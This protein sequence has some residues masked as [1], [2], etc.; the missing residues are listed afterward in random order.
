MLIR[1]K[2][3]PIFIYG[4]NC[5]RTCLQLKKSSRY[6]KLFLTKSI[7]NKEKNKRLDHILD[8]ARQL[9]V[10][11]EENV[12]MELMN[13][14]SNGRPHQ[15][16]C[17]SIQP[18]MENKNFENFLKCFQ[19]SNEN[20][21]FIYLHR[22]QDPMNLGGIL[23]TIA[24]FGY[25]YVLLDEHHCCPISPI[26]YRASTGMVELLE[27][28]RLNDK[29]IVE[30]F[31][32]INKSQMA[33][34]IATVCKNENDEM[35]GTM[36]P[37]HHYMEMRKLGKKNLIIFGN[38]EIGINSHIQRLSHQLLTIEQFIPSSSLNVHVAVGIFLYQFRR[39]ANSFP[40]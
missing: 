11:V 24:Y 29:S 39:M 20:E 3:K 32:T 28:F 8:L 40:K 15:G 4:I 25:K 10:D 14:M 12:S 34:I 6:N 16:T 23:R 5:V 38:E 18:I 37:F 33:T 31:K 1:S 9:N 30:C 2:T 19:E 17:L 26:V 22:I 35:N 13:R 27:L 21:T 7:D 36:V